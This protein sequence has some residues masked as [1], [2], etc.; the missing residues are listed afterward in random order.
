MGSDNVQN[1]N[2]PLQGS[3]LRGNNK[4]NQNR[5]A[6]SQPLVP[7]LTNTSVAVLRQQMDD[8]NHEL[9]NRLTNQMGNIF[10]PIVQESAETNSQSAET[11][12]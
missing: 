5:V 6:P 1:L 12:R 11:N 3:A 2:S 8:N 9:V 10:N 7:P 4:C